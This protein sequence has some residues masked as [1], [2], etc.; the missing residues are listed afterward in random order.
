[1]VDDPWAFPTTKPL[2]MLTFPETDNPQV[3]AEPSGHL[4]CC[5]VPIIGGRIQKVV[6]Y[7]TAHACNVERQ[8]IR[9]RGTRGPCLEIYLSRLHA[10]YY[11]FLYICFHNGA[12]RE[13]IQTTSFPAVVN[14]ELGVWG[15]S[16]MRVLE[17]VHN[18]MSKSCVSLVN[19]V[20]FC[21]SG[22]SIKFERSK[23]SKGRT[24]F[25]PK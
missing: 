15:C 11:S 8:L 18:L 16:L 20:S 5:V 21:L 23:R 17:I 9:T 7:L 19:T 14:T 22:E 1:M 25:E 4:S 2:N 24:W 13:Y 12:Q 6:V 3:V 10:R